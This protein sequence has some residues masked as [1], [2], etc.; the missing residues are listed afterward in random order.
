MDPKHLIETFGTLG[1]IGIIFAETGLLVGFFLPGDPAALSH[2]EFLKVRA[3]DPILTRT[4]PLGAYNSEEL[5]ARAQLFRQLADT[6][7]LAETQDQVRF[8]IHELTTPGTHH[9]SEAY[10]RVNLDLNGDGIL[11]D[12]QP[13]NDAPHVWEHAYLYAAAMVAFGS[14]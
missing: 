7:S 3:I 9:I 1:V 2:A 14:R 4:A 12:Y 11:P 8:F 5:L 13:Q 10:A 6:A